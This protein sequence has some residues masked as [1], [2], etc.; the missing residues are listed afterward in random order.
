[1]WASLA[2]SAAMI[3]APGSVALSCR[4]A[5]SGRSRRQRKRS[6]LSGERSCAPRSTPAGSGV[7]KWSVSGAVSGKNALSW[8]AAPAASLTP[9]GL[10][11]TPMSSSAMPSCARS[12]TSSET[13]GASGA[14][15]LPPS[16]RLRSTAVAAPSAPSVRI[17]SWLSTTT[18]AWPGRAMRAARAP[19]HA[20]TRSPA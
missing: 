17:G 5:P 9:I 15:P 1:M 8:L 16:R 10:T 14:K 11:A 19:S 13:I 12:P 4:R 7:T 2:P 20:S 6:G 3:S 18:S